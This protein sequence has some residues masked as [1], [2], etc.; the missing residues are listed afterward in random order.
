MFIFT[1]FCYTAHLKYTL[2][3]ILG[4]LVVRTCFLPQAP[5]QALTDSLPHFFKG[6]K[7]VGFILPS[8]PLEMANTPLPF[9][10]LSLQ[11][12]LQNMKLHFVFFFLNVL[13]IS[14]YPFYF[15][16][17]S[18]NHY[19]ETDGNSKNSITRKVTSV[20]EIKK[21]LCLYSLTHGFCPVKR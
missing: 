19:G 15:K 9:G 21:F 14:T 3:E 5:S 11:A 18:A 7:E 10:G 1:Y 16:E 8:S 13:K 12:C 17:L 4:K 20:S 2:N 6:F